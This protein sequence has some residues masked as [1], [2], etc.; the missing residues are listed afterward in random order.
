LENATIYAN[1]AQD[2][3]T[4]PGIVGGMA[5]FYS[6]AS[7]HNTILTGN[8]THN[9]SDMDGSLISD[10]YNI[11]TGNTCPTS[12]TTAHNLA[13]DPLLS[14][15]TNHWGPSLTLALLPGSPAIDAGD[16]ASCPATDQRGFYRPVD[17]DAVP[18]ALCDI[19]AFEF[20]HYFVFIPLLLR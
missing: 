9:C 3:V 12:G 20:G 5:L 17:G 8:E 6:S 16:P 19:G 2:G 10:D 11:L 15:L 7:I 18:G 13:S 14:A 4:Y 1:T